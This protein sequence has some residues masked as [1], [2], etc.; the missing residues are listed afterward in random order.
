MADKY[1]SDYITISDDDGKEYELEVLNT[2]EYNGC[3]YLAVI[4]A[5]SDPSDLPSMQIAIIKSVEEN[6]ESILYTVDD[7]AELDAVNALLVESIFSDQF[8][9]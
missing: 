6:G 2:L 1:G 3:N 4:P 7:D 5:D 9:E 8:E